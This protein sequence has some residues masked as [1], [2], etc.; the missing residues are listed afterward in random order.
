MK[1]SYFIYR[2]TS[3]S[4]KQY[5]GQ[6]KD[7]VRRWGNDGKGYSFLIGEE[8]RKYGWINFKKEIL[9]SNL[10]LEEANKFEE[11]LS[12]DTLYPKGLNLII[13]GTN[14]SFSE[15]SKQKIKAWY[16]NDKNRE[17]HS[18][19][20]KEGMKKF[21]DSLSK[22]E[23]IQKMHRNFSK[24]EIELRN[25]KIKES[26]KNVDRE[27]LRKKIQESFTEERRQ[28]TKILFA[29]MNSRLTKEDRHNMGLKAWETRRKRLEKQHG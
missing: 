5:I 4:G 9:F 27:K 12:K 1:E 13:G 6:M 21:F 15:I 16:L 29:E 8:I 23:R 22:E 17:S 11:D 25:K 10:T 18:E 28:K 19:K 14:K 2:L 26:W 24:K 7:Y 20:T 3:P